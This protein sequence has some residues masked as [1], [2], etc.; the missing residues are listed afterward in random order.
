[1]AVSVDEQ[2][3]HYEG[4]PS[5]GAQLEVSLKGNNTER[6]WPEYPEQPSL[7]NANLKGKSG[8]REQDP[9]RTI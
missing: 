6:L 2:Q 7:D 1:M 4:Q 5:W 3:N 9:E 8:K